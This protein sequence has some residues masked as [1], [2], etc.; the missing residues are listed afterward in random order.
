VSIN[1]DIKARFAGMMTSL[2]YIILLVLGCAAALAFIV[3]YNLTNINIT[4]RIREIATI[5]VL[6]FYKKET[7]SYVFRENVMLTLVGGLV[8]LAVGKVLH[9]FIMDC[10]KIDMVTFDVHINPISYV[11]SVGLTLLFALCVNKLMEK[12]LERISMTES[13]KSV[14]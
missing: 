3:I 8:G 12:K 13:L 11:Y 10:I 9:Q 2:D 7:A 5:K 4:E 6:G 1:E 14:D